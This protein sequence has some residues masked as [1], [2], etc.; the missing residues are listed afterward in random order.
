MWCCVSKRY[1]MQYKSGPTYPK[2][3]RFIWGVCAFGFCCSV[4]CRFLG[5]VSQKGNSSFR[6]E[7]KELLNHQL[8]SFGFHSWEFG[9]KEPAG[10]NRSYSLSRDIG[11][12]YTL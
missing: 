8:Y 12:Q 7:T 11:L 10:K 5:P 1:N 9:A 4:F 2:S 3:Q 6:K